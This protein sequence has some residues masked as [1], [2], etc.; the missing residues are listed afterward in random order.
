MNGYWSDRGR[1]RPV[2]SSDRVLQ[3]TGYFVTSDMGF[4]DAQGILSYLGRRTDTIRTGGETVWCS[5]VEQVLQKHPRVAECAV[6]GISDARFGEV[7]CCA[8]VP[9]CDDIVPSFD[10]EEIRS[11][12]RSN[13]LAGYKCPRHV[14]I[15]ADALPRNT[16]GK[17]LKYQLHEQLRRCRSNDMEATSHARLLSKL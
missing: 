6:F 12:C 3:R 17:V 2:N 4:W 8:V 14:L 1:S 9:S 16:N 11:W 13:G 7:V 5:E 10:L 15:R